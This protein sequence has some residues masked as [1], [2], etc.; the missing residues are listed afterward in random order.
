MARF[1]LLCCGFGAPSALDT[2]DS[3]LS[4]HIGELSISIH[5][6]LTNILSNEKNV[7]DHSFSHGFDEQQVQGALDVL[8]IAGDMR[9]SLHLF[10]EKV[11]DRL[12]VLAEKVDTAM[13][14][15]VK[16]SKGLSQLNF[17]STLVPDSM[18]VA[19]I[20]VILAIE[21]CRG[22]NDSYENTEKSNISKSSFVLS[23]NLD[24]CG[25]FLF[26]KSLNSLDRL[27]KSSQSFVFDV[28]A[29]IPLEHLKE[30]NSIS[31]WKKEDSILSNIATSS[32]GTLPQSYITHVGEHLLG[33]VQALEPFASDKNAMEIAKSAM[34]G[35]DYLTTKYWRD[36]AHAINLVEDDDEFLMSLK[37][38][39]K[40]KN[41]VLNLMSNEID[42]DDSVDENEAEAQEFC[43]QWLD[44]ICSAVTGLLLEKIMRIQ[45]LSRKGCEHL[46]ID[47]NY[48]VNVLS[49]LGV[50]GHPHPLL[51]HILELTKLS[52]DELKARMVTVPDDSYGLRKI[53]SRLLQIRGS[54]PI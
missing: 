12:N 37:K 1:E 49:A 40:V 11:R 34:Q 48:I 54:S 47:I 44:I 38:G 23:N 39:D 53:E 31:S 8:K 10:H 35:M 45:Y 30:M 26:P 17:D 52:P 6:L 42:D 22:K 51:N 16:I 41:M 32:Y 2:I 21:H 18:S 19:D 3:L 27:T 36:F 4:R 9:R 28:C 33:L 20:E 24:D 46:S 14:Q 50:N 15:D 13:E 43:N 29:S 25:N 7:T 5:T